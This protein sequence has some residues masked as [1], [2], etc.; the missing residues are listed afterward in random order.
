[1]NTVTTALAFLELGDLPGRTTI[2][3]MG[4]RRKRF[5]SAKLR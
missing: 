3:R 1:M 2:P 5:G 4:M